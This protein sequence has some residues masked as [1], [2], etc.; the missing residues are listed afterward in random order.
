MARHEAGELRVC[1][2]CYTGYH[3]LPPLV[4]ALRRRHPDC[5]LQVM[6]E[7]TLDPIAALLD[8]RLD[9]AIV[10]DETDDRRLRCR[11]LFTDEHVALV[12]RDHP[13]AARPFVSPADLAEE[14]LYLYSRSIDHSFLVQHV[15]RP[16]GI[17]PARVTYLQLTEGIVEMVRAGL[18]A[19]VLPRWSIGHALATGEVSAVRITRGGVFRPWYA[20]TLSGMTPTPFTEEFIRL[21]SEHGPAARR[22]ADSPGPG[23]P[24]AAPAAAPTR[25]RRRRRSRP[26]RRPS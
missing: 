5:K 25:H 3:W 12:P 19:S 1:T 13:W 8:A 24:A 26:P 23:E 6:A 22:G 18:G 4:A 20:V 9:L 7:F 10:N 14:P 17:R 16:L 11:E 21:L 2:H 15:M